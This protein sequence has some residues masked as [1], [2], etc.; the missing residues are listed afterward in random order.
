MSYVVI[1]YRAQSKV[2]GHF[3]PFSFSGTVKHFRV[4]CK[5]NMM[6]TIDESEFCTC[7]TELVEVGPLFLTF[8]I[9]GYRS[10]YVSILSKW[11]RRAK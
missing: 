10:A 8:I 9:V 11:R 7:I 3:F 1:I 2:H 6:F 4:K 5:K